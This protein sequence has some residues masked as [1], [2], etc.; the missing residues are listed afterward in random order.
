MDLIITNIVEGTPTG[1]FVFSLGPGAPSGATLNPSSGVF[2]WTPACTQGG[3]TNQITVSVADSGRPNLVDS[4]TF[5]VVVQDCIAAQLGGLVLREGDTGRLPIYLFTSV[6]LTNLTALVSAPTNWLVPAGIE[7]AA[8]EICLAE[9]MPSNSPGE[10]MPGLGYYAITF[11]TCTNQ[12]LPG[13]QQIAWLVVAAATNQPSAFVRVAIGPTTGS[14]PDGSQLSSYLQ[15]AGRV[16]VVGEEP[17]VE[18]GP[19]GNGYI[20]L[21]LYA[22]PGTTNQFQTAETL[23]P[24]GWLPGQQVIPANLTTTLPP[25]PVTNQMLFFRV[26]RP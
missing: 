19:A 15:Q 6:P 26:R 2:D 4:V 8:Q 5:T 16:V 1:A 7:A 12:L 21:T 18:A 17:L 22:L 14:Q 24:Q 13:S 23:P 11:G 3:A 20:Q 10:S 25:Q 9:L